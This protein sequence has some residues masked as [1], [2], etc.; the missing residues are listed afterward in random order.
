MVSSSQPFPGRFCQS[1]PKH[2]LRT[3]RILSKNFRFQKAGGL[4][5]VERPNN[6]Y[7]DHSALIK[8]LFGI[9]GAHD[10]R[11]DAN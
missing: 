9:A 10:T 11:G 4:R 2:T 1:T 6:R 5:R 7:G 3:M 8:G